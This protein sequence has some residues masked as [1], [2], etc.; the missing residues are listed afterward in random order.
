MGNLEDMMSKASGQTKWKIK[1]SCLLNKRV[2]Y[3]GEKGDKNDKAKRLYER[4]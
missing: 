1:P 2:F 4:C 3:F